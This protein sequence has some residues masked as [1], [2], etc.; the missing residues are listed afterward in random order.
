MQLR[1]YNLIYYKTENDNVP[2]LDLLKKLQNS[3]TKAR[4]LKRLERLKHG[5]FGDYKHVGHGI[6]ELRIHCRGGLRI[7]FGNISKAEILLIF[8]G[9]K[10]TQKKDIMRARDLWIR[11]LKP[12]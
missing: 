4:I 3:S 12:A 9:S 2:F 1:D 8:G 7:Y 11:F 10:Q 5:N 6:W